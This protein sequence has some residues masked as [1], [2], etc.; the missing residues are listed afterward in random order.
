MSNEAQSKNRASLG[1]LGTRNM[2]VIRCHSKADGGA[3]GQSELTKHYRQ[4]TN[5]TQPQHP[6][7]N[8]HLGWNLGSRFGQG[9]KSGSGKMIATRLSCL[10]LL[11]ILHPTIHSSFTSHDLLSSIP[12]Q[13]CCWKLI[14]DEHANLVGLPMCSFPSDTSYLISGS[15]RNCSERAQSPLIR[16]LFLAHQ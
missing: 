15:A 6:R 16:T 12:S 2:N 1:L 8:R 3:E 7:L 5:S 14:L 13:Q 4:S 10:M 11:N 9:H